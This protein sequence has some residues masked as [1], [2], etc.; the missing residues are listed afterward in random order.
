MN[1]SMIDLTPVFQA[2]IALLAALVTYR[3]IPWIQSKTN[4][5]Q[6]E[7]LITAARIAVLAA[8]QVFGS[9]R[10]KEKFNYALAA[11][12][13]A[14]FNIDGSIAIAAIE[15]AVRDLNLFKDIPDADD[16]PKD[17]EEPV[18]VVDPLGTDGVKLDGILYSDDKPIDKV[19]TTPAVVGSD[20]IT[21]AGSPTVTAYNTATNPAHADAATQTITTTP[22]AHP[23]EPSENE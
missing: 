14:G 18:E 7:A 8:E 1:M 11:L 6:Q 9:G 2:I 23:P 19:T 4:K 13:A 10:G 17:Q 5:N 15:K 20:Y 22:E 21:T 16:E 3:L 12:K